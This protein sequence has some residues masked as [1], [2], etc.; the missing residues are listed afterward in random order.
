MHPSN[1]D[2]NVPMS[3]LPP[4][5]TQEQTPSPTTESRPASQIKRSSWSR[6]HLYASF[7]RWHFWVG[8]LITPVLAVV[9]ITGAIYV[10]WEE[11]SPVIYPELFTVVPGD[12]MLPDAQLIGILRETVPSEWEIHTLYHP[13]STDRSVISWMTDAAGT[14][15]AYYLNPYTGA[16]LGT[17]DE[18]SGFFRLAVVI[19]TSLFAG[20]FG[21]VLVELSTSWAIITM[22]T[23]LVLWWPRGKLRVRGVWVPRLRSGKRLFWRDLHAVPAMYFT[24][25]ILVVLITG[26]L[27]TPVAGR[28]IFAGL[29][30]ADQ[31]PE[32]Y[33]S[34]LKVPAP[35]GAT[36]LSADELYAIAREEFPFTTYTHSLPH[37]EDEAWMVFSRLDRPMDDGAMVW[38]NPYTGDIMDSVRFS[39][40]AIGG[41]IAL[42]FYPIHTGMIFGLGTQIL[43]VIVCLGLILASISGIVMWWRRRPPGSLGVPTLP[44]GRALPK[45]LFFTFA[46]CG[47]FLPTVGATFLILF[48]AHLLSGALRQIRTAR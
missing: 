47:L 19:H 44:P 24:P 5:V 21:R 3:P 25:L 8:L 11:L 13:E 10:F 23:G 26:L 4:T 15:H 31:I 40:M 7:W 38:M 1:S 37:A 22:L 2:Q 48:A 36:M 34:H 39:E 46:L 14:W 16:V 6:A 30:A 9:S 35:E 29:I 27:F 43:A 18:Y 17:H 45:Y 12:S 42:F 20:T 28:A 41:K 33:F 32:G